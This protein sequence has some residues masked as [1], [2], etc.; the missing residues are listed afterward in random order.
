MRRSGS[1]VTAASAPAEGDDVFVLGEPFGGFW[2]PGKWMYDGILM[3]NEFIYDGSGGGDALDVDDAGLRQT[4]IAAQA[5]GKLAV[6]YGE[7]TAVLRS[8]EEVRFADGRLVFDA[9]DTA[10]QVVRLYEA[11][12]DRLPGVVRMAW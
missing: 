3:P 1:S 6:T 2:P 7:A 4:N 9:D 11:A 5:D 12:L 10:A 8:I